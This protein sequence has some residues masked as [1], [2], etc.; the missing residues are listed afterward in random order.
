MIL[1]ETQENTKKNNEST[2]VY[3]N[4]TDQKSSKI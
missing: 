3:S 4:L 1:L 2:N